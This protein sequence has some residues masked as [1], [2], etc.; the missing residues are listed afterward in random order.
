MSSSSRWGKR[1]PL[2]KITTWVADLGNLTRGGK[3]AA[4]WQCECIGGGG[5]WRRVGPSTLLLKVTP[6]PQ[7]GGSQRRGKN[8]AVASRVANQILRRGLATPATLFKPRIC[9]IFCQIL[10][11]ISY[12]FLFCFSLSILVSLHSKR[13][14]PGLVWLEMT[15]RQHCK[16][17]RRVSPLSYKGFVSKNSP[18]GRDQL[19]RPNCS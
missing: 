14:E 7:Q 12:M 16:D 1:T 4:Q 6:T 19:Q 3:G 9:Q 15:A 11:E 13:E 5:R 10:S 8:F 17:G 18:S 2:S